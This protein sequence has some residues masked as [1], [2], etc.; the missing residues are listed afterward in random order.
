M[1]TAIRDHA[2]VLRYA[3]MSAI[4]DFRAIY[5]WRTWTFAWLIRILCQVS[6]F[7]LLG[8]LLGSP[9]KTSFL[10]IGN[11]VFMVA[12]TAT[13]VISS[14]A[15]ERMAGTLPLLVASPTAPFWVF[16]GRSVQWLLDGLSCSTVSLFLLAPLFDVPLPM[17]SALLAVPIMALTAVSTYCFALVLA[18]LVLRMLSLR[19]LVSS[20]SGLTLMVL[21]GVQV[22]ISFWPTPVR[23][24]AEVLPLTHGLQAV[25][26][27]L[28]G[29]AL[30]RIGGQAAIEAAIGVG[31]LLVAALAF[32]RF[33]EH[34][35]HDGSIEFG[36]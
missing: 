2:R 34:G 15:W 36:A 24:L 35:R 12:N 27:L 7:A 9:G 1:T 6:L 5:T 18:A 10:L 33:A 19:S 8:R 28:A 32:R 14:T 16:T 11:C 29:D 30:V 31:W 4:A 13:Q 20:L 23:Q 3:S 21:T 25:R 26:D 17:P 22:P